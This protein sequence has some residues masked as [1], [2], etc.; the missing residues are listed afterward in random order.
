[1][2][3]QYGSAFILSH[4]ASSGSGGG[5]ARRP[6]DAITSPARIPAAPRS[7]SADGDSPRMIAAK[8]TEQTGCSVSEIEVTTAGSRGSEIE[9]R[10]STR[11]NSSHEW[12]S[13]A[14]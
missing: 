10:K 2:L 8:S 13:Y 6:R 12:I 9:D 3:S 5:G 4:P 7:C 14:V 11:L 1:M